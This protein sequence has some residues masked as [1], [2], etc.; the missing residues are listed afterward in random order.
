MYG[1]TQILPIGDCV[2]AA[3]ATAEDAK[4]VSS[5]SAPY[6]QNDTDWDKECENPGRHQET[7]TYFWLCPLA[8]E[9]IP[10]NYCFPEGL[11]HCF[12]NSISAF[13]PEAQTDHADPVSEGILL[14]LFTGFGEGQGAFI[15]LGMRWR[16][17]GIRWREDSYSGDLGYANSL[18]GR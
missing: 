4:V 2:F 18:R 10:C 15:D 12:S 5:E 8:W 17:L 13:A 3:I 11:K 14:N 1:N 7:P 16:D 9:V 6:G